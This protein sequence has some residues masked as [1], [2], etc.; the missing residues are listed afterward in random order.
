MKRVALWVLVAACLSLSLVGV[1]S[2]K[3]ETAAGKVIAIDPDGKAI[4]IVKGSGYSART[5]GTIV[6]RDTIVKVKGKKAA[7]GNI[8]VGDRVIIK[9][10]RSDN[11][12]AKQIIKK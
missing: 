1:S 6:S 10:E 3:M 4:V 9:L 5:V 12:Y 2:A 7:L 11:Q 8:K